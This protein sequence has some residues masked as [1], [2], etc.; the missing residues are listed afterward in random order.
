MKICN[1]KSEGDRTS[2]EFEGEPDFFIHMGVVLL[3]IEE[4][5]IENKSYPT[6]ETGYKKED[7]QKWK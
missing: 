2:P 4:C 6:R 1:T 7:L 5:S 3:E